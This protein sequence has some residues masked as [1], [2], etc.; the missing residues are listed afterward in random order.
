M[1]TF[2]RHP[3]KHQPGRHQIVRAMAYNQPAHDPSALEVAMLEGLDEIDWAA[4]SHAYGPATDVPEWLRSLRSPDP[5]V[6]E[7]VRED[8]NIVHQGTGY[9]ATAP[10][11]PFLADLFTVLR[12][13]FLPRSFCRLACSRPPS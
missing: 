7:W 6:R 1:L 9:A 8:W 10:A 11:V 13:S 5:E 4:L 3:V 2:A 12:R